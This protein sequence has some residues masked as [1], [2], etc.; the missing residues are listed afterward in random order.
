M[1][2]ESHGKVM[3]FYFQISVG[4]LF[5]DAE[6]SEANFFLR[7]IKYLFTACPSDKYLFHEKSFLHPSPP[8]PLQIKWWF[9]I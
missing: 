7:G 2:M 1:V 9:V 6:R 4:T 5:N 3:E 8:P